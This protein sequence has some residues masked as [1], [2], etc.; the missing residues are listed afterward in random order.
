MSHCKDLHES[1]W[2][3]ANIKGCP[4]NKGRPTEQIKE[5]IRIKLSFYY[6]KRTFCVTHSQSTVTSKSVRSHEVCFKCLNTSPNPPL[7]LFTHF[8]W[9][10]DNRMDGWMDG[11]MDVLFIETQP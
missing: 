10:M 2:D 4:T 3:S 1:D 5:T 8:Q 9:Y 6:F 11:W 7:T